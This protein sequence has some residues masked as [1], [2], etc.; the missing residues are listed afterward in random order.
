MVTKKSIKEFLKL[1]RANDV[2]EARN[3]LGK[4]PELAHATCSPPPKKYEGQT[5]LQIAV[6]NGVPEIVD[7]LIDAGADV[8]YIETTVVN[9]WNSPVLNDAVHGAVRRTIGEDRELVTACIRNVRRLLQEGADPAQKDTRGHNAYRRFIDTVIPRTKDV[10]F[11]ITNNKNEID[12]PDALKR[13]S[14]I[15]DIH[16]LLIEF[17]AVPEGLDELTDVQRRRAGF[18]S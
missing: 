4:N 7:A 5:L 9:D 13:A 6:R 16:D 11:R 12:D 8:N 3:A 18:Q 1:I 10:Y 2:A 14:H 15:K 17:G